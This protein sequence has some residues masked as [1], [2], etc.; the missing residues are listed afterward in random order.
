MKKLFKCIYPSIKSKQCLMTFCST[1]V[2]ALSLIF[3]IFKN[4]SVE[5]SFL[6]HDNVK[7]IL[8]DVA[9]D[10]I[11]DNMSPEEKIS[12]SSPLDNGRH[13]VEVKSG[14]T[15]LNILTDI[16]ISYKHANDVFLSI[17]KV[18]NPKDLRVGQ[19][20]NIETEPSDDELIVKTLHI[21]ICTGENLHVVLNEDNT[22][23][24][25]VIKDD[26]VEELKSVQGEI[27]GILS[28]S[29][30][31]NGV[32]SKIVNSFIN[33][34]SYSVD[35]RRDIKKGDSYEI[36]YENYL[37][38]EGKFA[39][40]GN[41]IYAALTL[42]KNKIELYRFKD[43]G[44]TV[45]Y[46]DK[47]G[48]ALKKTLSR[49]PLAYQSKRIS[50]Y[51]GRRRHP[52]YKDIRVHWGVDYPAPTGTKIFAAGDGVIEVAQYRRGY[53]NYIKIR[54][55]SEYSTAYGHLNGYAKG[56]RSGVRVKQGQVIGYVGSTGRSTGPHLHYEVLHNG[57]RVDPLRV[58]AAASENLTGKNLSEFKK[59]I[60]KIDTTR[61]NMLASQNKE[62]KLAQ[63]DKN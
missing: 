26:L 50:S 60:A 62:E 10:D 15:L 38:P 12:E 48:L 11:L 54:H 56:I 45:D 28:V 52:I 43:S 18:F 31:E 47:K 57:K 19:V 36:M 59:Q 1:F 42:G 5:A 51:F 63:N 53:G 61:S 16:G 39:K 30:N 8:T 29:M 41:I 49:R 22:Y 9:K 27:N 32:P 55:N 4:N 3:I 37:T 14:D 24:S 21:N 44:G 35:F 58:K 6:P 23:S 33:I 40:H 34:F 25:K 2:V 20:V 46:Y 7:D 17:R 13:S